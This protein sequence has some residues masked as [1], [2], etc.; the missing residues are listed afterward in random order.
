MAVKVRPYKSGGWEVDIAFRFPDGR[1]HRERL[2]YPASSKSAT[3]RWGEDRQRHLLLH[4][5]PQPMKEV[6]LLRDF[7]PRIIDGHVRAN[8]VDHSCPPDSTLRWS[9]ARCDHS[10]RLP[11]AEV[12]SL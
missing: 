2:K 5:L 10:R 3:Q 12:R 9:T 1:R 8:G 6:P 11:G 4:G 7:T